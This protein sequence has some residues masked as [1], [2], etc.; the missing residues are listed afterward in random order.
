MIDDV[1]IIICF[2][3]NDQFVMTKINVDID[4]VKKTLINTFTNYITLYFVVYIH[5]IYLFKEEISSILVT[6]SSKLQEMH[7]IRFYS[8]DKFFFINQHFHQLT[9]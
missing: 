6:V 2:Q 5:I 9:G 1:E 3:S 7:E 4:L 8:S